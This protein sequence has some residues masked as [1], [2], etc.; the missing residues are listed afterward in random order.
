MKPFP[1]KASLQNVQTK[2]PKVHQYGFAWCIPASIENAAT[3]LGIPNITQQRLVIS[4][5]RT[6]GN[7]SLSYLNYP[8][9]PTP[10]SDGLLLFVAANSVFTDGNFAPFKTIVDNF[11]EFQNSGWHL[12]HITGASTNQAYLDE[13]KDAISSGN[14][15]LISFD[16]GQ[17][18]SHINSVYGY[19]QNNLE[20]HD[21]ATNKI[22]SIPLRKFKFRDD[23]LLF[24]K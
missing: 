23:L 5:A 12:K 14:P 19:N 22:D 10:L 16:N 20:V 18:G 8:I 7:G 15:I 24:H 11:P 13:I 17:G 3:Y 2:V 21:P 6:F 4:Y 1:V 9:D